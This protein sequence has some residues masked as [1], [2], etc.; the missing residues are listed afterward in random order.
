MEWIQLP[1][2]I[3][4]DFIIIIGNAQRPLTY[5]GFGITKANLKSYTSVKSISF[6]FTID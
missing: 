6:A 2:D 4:K 5:T 1:I 3:K